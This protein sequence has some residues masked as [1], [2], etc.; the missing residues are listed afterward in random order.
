MKYRSVMSVG[1]VAA[2]LFGIYLLWYGTAVLSMY[3]AVSIKEAA[4]Q[5]SHGMSLLVGYT[6]VRMIGTLVL[7]LGLLTW[8]IKGVSDPRACRAV[9][10]S[11]SLVF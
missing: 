10:R 4:A 3:E 7:G 8:V 11:S 6:H 5:D 1:A 9:T 2:F